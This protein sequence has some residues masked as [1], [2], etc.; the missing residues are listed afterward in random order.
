[1]H[2][3]IS[4]DGDVLWLSDRHRVL[5]QLSFEL[6]NSREEDSCI[7]VIVVAAVAEEEEEE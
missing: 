5:D 2:P 4:Q 3:S 1:M 7:V 6:Q